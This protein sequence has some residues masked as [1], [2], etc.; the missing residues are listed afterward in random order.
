[1]KEI[2]AFDL[3]MAIPQVDDG[4]RLLNAADDPNL[5]KLFFPRPEP[6][7]TSCRRGRRCGTWSNSPEKKN[8]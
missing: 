2:D 5:L 8:A 3:P 7:I 1:M 4:H 6:M